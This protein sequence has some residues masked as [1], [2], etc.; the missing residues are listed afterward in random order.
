M[1]EGLEQHLT[2]LPDSPLPPKRSAQRDSGEVPGLSFTFGRKEASNKGDSRV[3][4][5]EGLVIRSEA[6]DPQKIYPVL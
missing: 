6:G 1:G 4:T 5:Q 2:Q 3:K